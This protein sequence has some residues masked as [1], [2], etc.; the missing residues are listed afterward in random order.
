MVARVGCLYR[1]G[2]RRRTRPCAGNF[3]PLSL[4]LLSHCVHIMPDLDLRSIV[5][6]KGGWVPLPSDALRDI[7]ER[8]IA[9]GDVSEAIALADMLSHADRGLDRSEADWGKRWGWSRSRV[10]RFLVS[11]RTKAELNVNQQRTKREPKSAGT[12]M[13]SPTSEPT[14]NQVRTKREPNVNQPI[15][16]ERARPESESEEEYTPP[17]ER[18]RTPADGMRSMAG[19]KQQAGREIDPNDPQQRPPEEADV[20]AWAAGVGAV[21]PDVAWEIAESYNAT[22]WINRNGVAVRNWQ[23]G[24]R[25]AYTY[26]QRAGPGRTQQ[27]GN[28]PATDFQRRRE[29]SST[30][31]R[32]DDYAAFAASLPDIPADDYAAFAASLPNIPAK[33]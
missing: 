24:I 26:R 5:L 21:P 16:V 33:E 13:E 6:A 30:P 11:L 1:H 31:L 8:L 2:N 27:Q 17:L 3:L 14:L 25:A 20:K 15:Y 12:A 22:G 32:A 9:A 29:F 19:E 4:F 23:A 10:H 28:K 7:M 18:V